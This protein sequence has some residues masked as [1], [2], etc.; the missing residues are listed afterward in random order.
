M[1]HF[2]GYP[3]CYDYR[4]VIAP[5]LFKG[6]RIVKR[7]STPKL[8]V[9]EKFWGRQKLTD[10]VS[11][12]MQKAIPA[13]PGLTVHWMVV[14]GTVPAI[15]SNMA[16]CVTD[17]FNQEARRQM[18]QLAVNNVNFLDS[19][20]ASRQL[21]DVEKLAS[22]VKFSTYPVGDSESSTVEMAIFDSL[23]RHLGNSEAPTDKQ[24]DDKTA[25][26]PKITIP[27]VEH[28]L[29]KEQ[30]FFLKE[31]KNTVKRASHSMDHQ[32]HVQLGKVLSIL[33]NSP[34]LDQLLPELTAFFV[35]EVERSNGDM[36]T[37][38]K[39]AEA[40][41]ANEKIQIHYHVHQLV[42][43]LLTLILK[44]DEEHDL[45]SVHRNLYLRKLA[46]KTLGNLASSLRNSKSGLDGIDQYLMTLY[47]RAVLDENCSLTVLYGAMCGM[48]HLPLAAL[49]IVFF[50]IVPLIMSA[51][52]RKHVQAHDRYA[53]TGSKV[54]EFKFITCQEIVHLATVMLYETCYEDIL[55][56]VSDTGIFT[57]SHEVQVMMQ[58]TLDGSADR[59]VNPEVFLPLYTAIVSRCFEV[60]K[61]QRV[62]RAPE[63]VRHTLPE[64]EN[65]ELYYRMYMSEREGKRRKVQVEKASSALSAHEGPLDQVG[66]PWYI[67]QA[68]HALTLSI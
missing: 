34:A 18:L 24:A 58:E 17:E 10:I 3:S 62:I 40:I 21:E 11:R 41:A 12:D 36:E 59:S 9:D 46:A 20:D 48:S 23:Q 56:C 47:K 30:R 28:I 51:L 38:L 22:K 67:G 61:P 25:R 15:S 8:A 44:H 63:C 60:L 4:Y 1:E 6:N 50:P 2:D 19:S 5:K 55:E 27:R 32:I 54:E 16:Q 35:S 57:A 33:R 31:T 45:Q 52:Y 49:R 26:L 64:I 43:P 42:A 37:I 13:Q 29:T 39:F 68:T 7:E 65:A 66:E 14:N 53:R